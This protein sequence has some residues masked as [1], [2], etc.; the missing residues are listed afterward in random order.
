MF[1]NN[2]DFQIEVEIEQPS[3]EYEFEIEY[4]TN[5]Q[6]PNQNWNYGGG[7][8][9]N[10]HF[11]Q[12]IEI[13]YEP[14]QTNWNNHKSWGKRNNQWEVP[15]TGWF[16]QNNNKTDMYFQNFQ[17]DQQGN[18]WGHGSDDIGQFNISGRTDWN[19]SGFT[20]H[21]QYVGQHSVVYRGQIRDNVWA[22]KWEIPGNCNGHFQIRCDTPRWS[23]AFFQNNQKN[24]MQLDMSVGQHGVFGMGHDN[25]GGFLIRGECHGNQV[26][27]QKSYFGQ[28]T[29]LYSGRMSNGNDIKGEWQIPGN[30]SGKFHLHS[31]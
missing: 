22:G 25:V 30:C 3:N 8:G 4:E 14:V 26:Q 17:V 28:H 20:F 1:N 31:N 16:K 27:F 24:N 6:K 5:Y 29:V 11:Q 2:F 15:W 19:N 12:E 9:N 23:G 18:I 21:K 7:H 10:K 13:E